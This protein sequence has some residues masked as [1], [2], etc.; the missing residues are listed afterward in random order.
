M[1]GLV[2][3]CRKQPRRLDLWRSAARCAFLVFAAGIAL[4]AWCSPGATAASSRSTAPVRASE[5]MLSAGIK[6][7]RSPYCTMQE[8]DIILGKSERGLPQVRWA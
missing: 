1:A 5:A 8:F 3:V 4:A 2:A 6:Q 7:S